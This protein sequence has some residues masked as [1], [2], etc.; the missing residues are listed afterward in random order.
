MLCGSAWAAKTTCMMILKNG[1]KIKCSVLEIT[2]DS[3]IMEGGD[4]SIFKYSFSDI[5]KIRSLAAIKAEERAAMLAENEKK[6][7]LAE[8]AKAAQLAAQT[9]TSTQTPAAP[10]ELPTETTASSSTPAAT[11]TSSTQGVEEVSYTQVLNEAFAED[12]QNKSVVIEA[13]YL[14]SG[15]WKGYLIPK[16][17]KKA[18]YYVFQCVQPGAEPSVNAMNKSANGEVFLID[19]SLASGVINLKQGE[20]VKM[21]GHTKV[22]KRLSNAGQMEVYFIVEEVI[23]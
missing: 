17:I 4:G 22:V 10:A 6:K 16:F 8:Q 1:S 19:K 20:K 13:E 12:Y 18:K 15:F 7:A 5:Q 2:K 3:A 14:Q 21:R 11:T 23:K 9:A